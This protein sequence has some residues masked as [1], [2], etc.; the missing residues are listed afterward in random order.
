[1]SVVDPL[2]DLI[3]EAMSEEAWKRATDSSHRPENVMHWWLDA[4]ARFGLAIAVAEALRAA[5]LVNE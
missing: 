3:A 5:G 2:T 1:M 4:N